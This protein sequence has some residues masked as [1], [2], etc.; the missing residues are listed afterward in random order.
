MSTFT[1]VTAPATEGLRSY[2]YKVSGLPH[3]GVLLYSA[4][5]KLPVRMR[6]PWASVNG[7]S[8]PRY[9]NLNTVVVQTVHANND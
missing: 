7:Q 1:A 8:R 4:S 9:S 2:F 3:G 5:H 6:E